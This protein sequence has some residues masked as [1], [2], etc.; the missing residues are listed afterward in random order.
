MGPAS[1]KTVREF[2]RQR[3]RDVAATEFRLMDKGE[4]AELLRRYWAQFGITV[5][6]EAALDVLEDV[7]RLHGDTQVELDLIGVEE[8]ERDSLLA[9]HLQIHAAALVMRGDARLYDEK[10]AEGNGRDAR[11]GRAAGASIHNNLVAFRR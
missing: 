8:R 4:W 10:R 3:C 1:Y 7:L 2:F 11:G 9:A 5:S 6:Q